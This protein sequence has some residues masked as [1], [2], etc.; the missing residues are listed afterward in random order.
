MDDYNLIQNLDWDPVYL[1]G[2]FDQD[3]NDMSELWSGGD[4][5]SDSV[6]LNAMDRYY[7]IVE[8]IT[9]DDDTLCEAVEL[10]ENE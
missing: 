7:P 9:I 3:F 5:V 8:D 4:S 2:I 1:H 6:V 10:I